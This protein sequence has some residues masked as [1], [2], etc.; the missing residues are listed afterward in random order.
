MDSTRSFVVGRRMGSVQPLRF[1]RSY[2]F[3]LYACPKPLYAQLHLHH[4]RVLTPFSGTIQVEPCCC[5]LSI[6][7]IILRY[8]MVSHSS[9][10]FCPLIV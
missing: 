3:R 2:L 1:I 7:H 6:G 8:H 4:I 5:L 9:R 10:P